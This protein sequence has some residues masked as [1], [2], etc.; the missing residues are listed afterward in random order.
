MTKDFERVSVAT[1]FN[2][3]DVFRLQPSLRLRDSPI[4]LSYIVLI[5]VNKALRMYLLTLLYIKQLCK[6]FW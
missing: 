6:Y 4:A 5:S 1:I 2:D 3:K